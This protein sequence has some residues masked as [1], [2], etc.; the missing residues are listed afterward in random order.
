M[1]RFEF[2]YIYWGSHESIMA[3]GFPLEVQ[4]KPTYLA[5]TPP[6]NAHDSHHAKTENICQ[7]RFA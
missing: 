6:R 3:I 4:A 1:K 7:A 5:V 2:H